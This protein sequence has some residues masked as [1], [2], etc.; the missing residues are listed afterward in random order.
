MRIFTV[1]W[2]ARQLISTYLL[3]SVLPRSSCYFFKDLSMCLLSASNPA[4]CMNSKGGRM[5]PIKKQS[6]EIGVISCF[7]GTSFTH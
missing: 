4:V 3:D 7:I 5:I 2:G 1:H 6:K